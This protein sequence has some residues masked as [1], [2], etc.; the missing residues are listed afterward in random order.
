LDVVL[1]G[2]DP[3]GVARVE[4]RYD[5][6]QDDRLGSERRSLAIDSGGSAY[7]AADRALLGFSPQGALLWR[8]GHPSYAVAVDAADSVLVTS[9][10]KPEGQTSRFAPDGTSRMHVD[11][12]G[13]AI[14]PTPDGGAWIGGTL[15]T[16]R[17]SAWDLQTTRLDS[18][19]RVVFTDRYD[20]GLQDRFVD[21]A[22]DGSG[23][24]YVLASSYVRSGL[25][26]VA[27]RTL[28]LKLSAA[29]RRAW[30][31]TYGHAGLPAALALTDDG[32]IVATGHDGTASWVEKAAQE[33]PWWWPGCW[34]RPDAT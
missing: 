14:A 31:T 7:V 1:L 27:D 19:G 10:L 25:F 26:G 13:F 3:A 18:H 21:L 34:V 12:G 32:R 5:S 20:G 8:A 23:D 4:A 15:V 2:F 24:A 22:V 6:G 30:S 28:L 33:C 11:R 29:D 17:A 16:D 9:P